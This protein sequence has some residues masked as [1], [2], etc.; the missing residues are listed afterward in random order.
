MIYFRNL[1]SFKTLDKVFE[2]VLE[3]EL[4]TRGKF[5]GGSKPG[6][7]DYMIWPWIERMS[8]LHYALGDKA[9]TPDK[10][11]FEKVINWRS[12]MKEDPAVK[13]SII[14]GENHHKFVQSMTT[15]APLYDML[16]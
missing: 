1:A 8:V 13:A 12:E 11:R 2:E 5:F 14:S 9:P 10:T 15:D 7:V 16:A 6:F 4:K 3:A